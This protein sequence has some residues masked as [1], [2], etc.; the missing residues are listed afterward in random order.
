MACQ[1]MGPIGSGGA[2]ARLAVKPKGSQDMSLWGSPSDQEVHVTLAAW[3]AWCCCPSLHQP[4]I[5]QSCS[6]ERVSRCGRS[7]LEEIL[8]CPL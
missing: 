1:D 2:L 7:H 8:R 6:A 3:A 5:N 4:V